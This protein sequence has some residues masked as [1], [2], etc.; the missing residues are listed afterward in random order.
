MPALIAYLH[1]SRNTLTAVGQMTPSRAAA[2]LERMDLAVNID[3]RYPSL[4]RLAFYDGSLDV[5]ELIDFDELQELLEEVEAEG[6]PNAA[7]ADDVIRS[8][9]DLQSTVVM[10]AEYHDAFYDENGERQPPVMRYQS[11][12]PP[13]QRGATR[14][15]GTVLET[16]FA[17][18]TLRLDGEVLMVVTGDYVSWEVEDGGELYTAPSI[19]REVLEEVAE[20]LVWPPEWHTL[21]QIAARF[22]AACY[23]REAEP[24]DRSMVR[25]AS[26]GKQ[27]LRFGIPCDPNTFGSVAYRA[28]QD[29]RAEGSCTAVF[30]GPDRFAADCGNLRLSIQ[31]EPLREAEVYAGER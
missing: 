24:L 25:E 30:G 7:N 31:L 22:R 27:V 2:I 3:R 4:A 1:S 20:L 8:M 23:D 21:L 10:G 15:E 18:Q 11:P 26:S 17:A 5:F 12:P 14:I 13:G 6:G 29:L 9:T 16:A 19:D 28:T